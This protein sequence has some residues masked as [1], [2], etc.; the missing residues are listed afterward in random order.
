MLKIIKTQLE[1]AKGAWPEE[2]PNV[3]WACRITTRVPMGETP[4]KL[5]FGTEA[6]IP[7]EVGLTNIR[8]KAYKEQKNHQ[9]LNNNLDLIDEVRDRAIK[10]MERYKGAMGRYYNKKVKVRRFNIGDLVLRKFMQDTKDSS[11]GKLGPAWEGPFQ[12]I[13]HSREGLDGQ[14]LHRPWNIEH[15]KRYYQ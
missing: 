15:L 7:M 1:G 10:W 8:I 4:F 6:V 14:E 13:C 2:L 11:Q 3:L 12:A 9:E 5:M